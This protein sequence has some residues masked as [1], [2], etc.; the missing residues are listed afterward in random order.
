MASFLL[1]VFLFLFLRFFFFFS[2]SREEIIYLS[3]IL[4]PRRDAGITLS[5]VPRT[6][7]GRV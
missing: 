4:L 2:L 6:L 3:L 7:K 5:F 1:S